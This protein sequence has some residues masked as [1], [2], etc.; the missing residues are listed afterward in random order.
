MR[1]LRAI[2][3][4]I[5]VSA[6]VCA[7]AQDAT[8]TPAPGETLLHPSQIT[9][10]GHFEA[11]LGPTAADR[12]TR[13]VGEQI[14]A[15]RSADAAHSQL[16]PLWDLAVW[17]YLPV[18]PVRTLN[19]RVTSDDDPFFTPEYLKISGQQLDYQLKLSERASHDLLH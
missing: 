15:K 5:A 3:A 16:A 12:A 10:T 18:D 6:R 19:S 11:P 13:V 7:R 2:L 14:D 8:S 1:Y 9:I 4:T 17:R